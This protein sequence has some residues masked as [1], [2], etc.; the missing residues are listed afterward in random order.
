MTLPPHLLHALQTIT[1]EEGI[2]V[3][4]LLQRWTST[5]PRAVTVR[6]WRVAA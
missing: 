1:A 3:A 2:T 4:D 5:A 6:G